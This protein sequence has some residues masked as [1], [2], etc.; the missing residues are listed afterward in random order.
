[1]KKVIIL[2][3]ISVVAIMIFL[4][5]GESSYLATEVK[6]ETVRGDVEEL[7][8]KSLFFRDRYGDYPVFIDNIY[9]HD[10][11]KVIWATQVFEQYLGKTPD[12]IAENI[13]LVDLPLMQARGV[14]YNLANPGNKYFLDVRTGTLLSPDLIEID[15]DYIERIESGSS[16]YRPL[17]DIRI[18][19]GKDPTK[20]MTTVKGSYRAGSTVYFYGAGTM[21][22]ARRSDATNIIENLDGLLPTDVVIDEIVYIQQITNKAVVKSGGNLVVVNLK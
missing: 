22:Y 4:N 3:M 5:R 7:Q 15:P 6:A 13:K 20:E 2:L 12:Y 17:A 10:D 1:M 16:E 21:K 18:V 19:D 14:T 9:D 8:G 11:A